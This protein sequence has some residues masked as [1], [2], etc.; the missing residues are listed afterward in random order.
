MAAIR[1]SRSDGATTTTATST[2]TSGRRASFRRR[3]AMAPLRRR[4]RGT[5]T[6]HSS[7][8]S[9]CSSR[10]HPI[11]PAC[12]AQPASSHRQVVRRPSALAELAEHRVPSAVVLY[13]TEPE[14][15]R[16]HRVP[17]GRARCTP[18]PTL[19]AFL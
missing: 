1:A 3:P 6:S 15:L 2:T 12:A 10:S 4:R 5:T 18:R 13:S 16:Y 11:F 9:L 17:V 8:R 14:T 19:P 7:H